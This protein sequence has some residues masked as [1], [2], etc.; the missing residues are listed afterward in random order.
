MNRIETLLV[1][2]ENLSNAL[3]EIGWENVLQVI[4]HH[5][6]DGCMYTIIYKGEK[7]I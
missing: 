3:N 4:P 7:I 6:Y 1:V 2:Y 5:S